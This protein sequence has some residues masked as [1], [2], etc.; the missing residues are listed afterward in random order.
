MAITEDTNTHN[1]AVQFKVSKDTET[2][3]VELTT[4]PSKT[5][6]KSANIYI[7]RR[8]AL[9]ERASK[10][11]W[12]PKFDSKILEDHLWKSYFPQTRRRFQYTL[13][14]VAIACIAWIIFFTSMQ[15]EHW[16]Q[17]TAGSGAL[18]VIVVLITLFTKTRFYE[19]FYLLTSI[20]FTL[21]ISGVLLTPFAFHDRNLSTVATFAGSIEVLLL[22]YT[23]IPMPLFAAVIVGITFSVGYETVLNVHK[24]KDNVWNSY[25]IIIAKILLHLCIH[26]IGIH[27]FTMSQVR[28]RSTFWKIGQSAIARRDL[29]IEKQLK[30]KM[31]H[32]LMPPSVAADVMRSREDKDDNSDELADGRKKRKGKRDKGEIIFRPFNM[33]KMSNVS[34]LFADIVGFTKMS[35]NKTAEHLVGLLNDLFGRFDK[36]CTQSG[37]E[38]ISTL[39]D[40]YYC[41]CGCPEQREDH[42][43]CCVEMGLG[44]IKA[45][46]EFD[47]E[48]NESVNMRVGVHTGT[49]LCGI[50]GTRRFKFDVWSNDVT[51]ANIMEST[52][53]PGMVHISDPTYRFLKDE[54]EVSSGED[55]EDINTNKVLIEHYDLAKSSFTIRHKEEQNLI[56]TYFIIGRNKKPGDP[57]SSPPTNSNSYMNPEDETTTKPDVSVEHLNP[58]DINLSESNALMETENGANGVTPAA[59]LG[60]RHSSGFYAGS[61]TSLDLIKEA[62]LV[63]EHSSGLY[64]I[65]IPVSKWHVEGDVESQVPIDAAWKKQR[66]KRDKDDQQIIKCIEEDV[67][68]DKF[69]YE[70]NINKLT[71]SFRDRNLESDFR[72]HYL[73]SELFKE[74]TVA[75]PRYIALLEVIFSL[76]VYMFITV[77]CWALF[78]RRLL[79]ILVF[80]VTLIIE[81]LN[82]VNVASDVFCRVRKKQR[83][84][85]MMRVTSGWYFRN[86]LGSLIAALPAVVVF[87]NL[88][89][90]LIG[91][92]SHHIVLFFYCVFVALL[93][94]CNFTM[95]SSWIKTCIATIGGM[96]LIVISNVTVC[97]L[98]SADFNNNTISNSSGTNDPNYVPLLYYNTPKHFNNYEMILDVMILLFLI[99]FINRE[100]EISY[101][102][103]YHGSAQA[104]HDKRTM[105]ENKDQAD[106]LLHNIIPEHVSELVKKTSKYSKNHKDCGVIFA[107]LVNFNEFYDES[108]EGGREYLRVLNELISDYEVLLDRDEFQDVEK[109]KTICS[110]F[111]AASGLNEQNRMKNK[112]PYAH[113]HALLNFAMELQKAVNRFNESI[114]NFEFILNVGFNF[115]EVTAGVIG[116]TKLLYDIWGDTV[117]I[118]SRMYS[119]GVA[120]R[121]QVPE[122]AANLL[123]DA[124]EFEYR[125]EIFVKGKGQ[126]R[127]YLV[128]KNREDFTGWKK[129]RESF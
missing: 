120:N 68:N 108:Y 11:W 62:L 28:R 72:N 95:L 104:E 53:Q 70:P 59:L 73:E 21:I 125:G 110:T 83:C 106:W 56:K 49:V 47:Y 63:R 88:S 38:K 8:P 61:T 12:D 84:D 32:S 123:S 29:Q 97:P 96:C 46:K 42:A 9:F 39:G 3:G 52:G 44:M 24:V 58:V 71:L 127:T 117:N 27:I 37:C 105:Q 81:L 74:E 13:I 80:V 2:E 129:K 86:F 67:S 26:L 55:V 118:A 15:E 66:E 89:C 94:F 114:F 111:M 64:A 5:G 17:F 107:T 102:S 98:D 75:S 23:F 124:F 109:I 7:R 77:C 121:I 126:M 36:L 119:T 22:I 103:S 60:R 16:K 82:L 87:S 93:H 51:L 122:A 99:F 92:S 1:S 90:E 35:S 31:I 54:Y 30:E 69:F 20:V 25:E 78:D 50:V 40:C 33:N 18:F 91:K 128:V 41:V 14:F 113:L 43:R 6:N 4:S 65:S 85:S 57:S 10:S 45:I 48:N 34:I 101:R 116:T 112:H 19:R 100:F 115:G 79:W 76:L